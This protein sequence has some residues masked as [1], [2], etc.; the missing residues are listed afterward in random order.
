MCIVYSMYYVCMSMYVLCVYVYLCVYVLYYMY[1]HVC[2]CVCIRNKE[3][4]CI[5]NKIKERNRMY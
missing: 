4:R 5:K 3:I 1:M 2:M